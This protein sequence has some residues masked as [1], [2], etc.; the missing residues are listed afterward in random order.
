MFLTVLTLTLIQYNLW[1]CLWPCCFS[2]G[3]TFK[4]RCPR[5]YSQHSSLTVRP[6]RQIPL[7]PLYMITQPTKPISK[8]KAI[9]FWLSYL[10]VHFNDQSCEKNVFHFFYVI[11]TVMK[12]KY[13]TMKS[14]AY[15]LAFYALRG[16]T[17]I[18]CLAWACWGPEK[19]SLMTNFLSFTYSTYSTSF[20]HFN[21]TYMPSI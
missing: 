8:A 18:I 20:L 19:S 17:C 3:V 4:H 5:Y 7:F 13:I 1:P 14:S 10:R 16:N 21:I 2:D 11:F 6:K 9:F 12:L 15:L